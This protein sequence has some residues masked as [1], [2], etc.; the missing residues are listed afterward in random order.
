MMHCPQTNAHKPRQWIPAAPPTVYGR[1][2]TSLLTTAVSMS[3]VTVWEN[4]LAS[5]LAEWVWEGAYLL[6]NCPQAT[7]EMEALKPGHN[8][9]WGCGDAGLF[10][11][12]Q[13]DFREWEGA[14]DLR[15][16]GTLP[17]RKS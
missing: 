14:E 11:G 16:L 10:G 15:P 3:T 13:F 7:G 5:Q 4:F 9:G 17:G 1:S 12:F 2:N 6:V 8:Q